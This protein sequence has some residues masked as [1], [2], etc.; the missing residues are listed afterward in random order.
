[1]RLNRARVLLAEDV[2]CLYVHNYAHHWVGT[3]TK[4]DSCMYTLSVLCPFCKGF[5]VLHINYI[6]TCEHVNAGWST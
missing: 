2:C 6:K 3:Y 4:C 1:M 5:V